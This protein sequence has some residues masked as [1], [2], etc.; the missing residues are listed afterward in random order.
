MHLVHQFN[1]DTCTSITTIIVADR[2]QI[3]FPPCLC[4]IQK[5]HFGNRKL[6]GTLFRICTDNINLHAP[7]I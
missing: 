4:I 5:W 7:K 3:K 1:N 2:Q 6:P